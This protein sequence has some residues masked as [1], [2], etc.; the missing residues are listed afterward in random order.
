MSLAAVPAYLIARRLL[1]P[2]LS[3]VVAAL[4]V[5]V[6][7]MLFTGMV[8]TENVFYPLFLLAALA[9]LAALERPTPTRQLLLLAACALAFLARQQAVALFAA[10]ATAPIL[11]T[12]IERRGL[13]GLRPW[14]TVYGIVAGGALL[15]LV[16]TVARGRS[17]T[18]LLGA[19]RARPRSTQR[20]Q[21]PPLPAWH[22]AELDLYLGIVPS[23]AR[24]P[25]GRAAGVD[26]AARAFAAASLA[27]VP[28][29]VVEVAAFASQQSERIEE[30]NMSTSRRSRSSRSSGCRGGRRDA[31]ARRPLRGGGAPRGAPGVHPVPALHHHERGL[32]TFALLPR[33]W[34]QDHGVTLANLRWVAL[35]V[36]LAAADC[37]CSCRDGTRS[38]SRRS[39]RVLRRDRLRGRERPHGSTAP[40]SARSGRHPGR[41]P[42]LDRPR[43]RPHAAVDYV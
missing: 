31:P 2:G 30:R 12:L 16:G 3:L 22:V 29:L 4:T 24:R 26:P 39:W 7:S 33:W 36:G 1:A 41:A 6:P 37:S 23:R 8:M 10:A 13:R 11:H 42:R 15:A 5:A 19:Y 25:F 34:V 17:V 35:G 38:S 21:R 20:R 32:D 18:T 40:R 9:L 14:T 28:W 43:G 27:L